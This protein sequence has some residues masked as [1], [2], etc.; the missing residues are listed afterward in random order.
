MCPAKASGEGGRV[1]ARTDPPEGR[2]TERP[3]ADSCLCSPQ[4]YTEGGGEALCRACAEALLGRPVHTISTAAGSDLLR[5]AR[6]LVTG[7]GGSVGVALVGKLLELQPE[8]VT[9]IDHSET[10]LFR[11]GREMGADSVLQLRLADVRNSNK[12]RRVFAESRPQVAF[13]LAAYKHVPLGESEPDEAVSVNVL[14][15]DTVVRAAE[16]AGARSFVYPSS[17]KSANPSSVYGATKRLAETL[18]LARAAATIPSVHVVRY[19][20]ILGSRG[21][22]LE[23][24]ARQ[25]RAGEPLTLTDPGMTRFW[26]AMDEATALLLHALGQPS[27]SHILLQAGDP[28]SV[29]TMAA[30]VHR[31]VRGDDSAPRF[32]AIGARLGERLAEELTG[33]SETLLP[34]SAS[35]VWRVVHARAAEQAAFAPRIVP[36]LS[37]L[38]ARG[39]TVRL[40]E[41]VLELARFLQ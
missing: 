35:P 27:G 20:N 14:G 17:D 28:I 37:A 15:T 16:E 10:S 30:R 39:D 4:T 29:Q 3:R 12:M 24:F 6:I 2:A 36:K 40:R 1:T 23:T 22:A 7:A 41:R 31:L 18:V 5:G 8:L 33:A 34:C 13:H 19:V 26:M 25:A 21:S 32:V 9:A 11:L 38:L